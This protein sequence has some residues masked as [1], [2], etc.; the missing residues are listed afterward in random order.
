MKAVLRDLDGDPTRDPE[1]IAA[2]LRPIVDVYKEVYELGTDRPTA[3]MEG[4][5]TVYADPELTLVLSWV[6]K[7]PVE[8]LHNHGI[9]NVLFVCEGSMQFTWC[10][11]LD[12][13]SEP[14][15]CELEVAD[16]RI[17]HVGDAGAVGHAPHDIHGFQYLE[18]PTWIITAAPGESNPS[19][20][21]YD[22]DAGTYYL[23][24]LAHA[25][26]ATLQA[27]GA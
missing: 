24:S 26:A 21:I 10:K 25:H 20:E 14:G 15:K 4:S 5:R 12:D 17:M 8:A 13:R 2:S 19:R 18:S 27:D 22:L 3:L 16:D 6:N 23:S 11:R 9:W 1:A 7:S